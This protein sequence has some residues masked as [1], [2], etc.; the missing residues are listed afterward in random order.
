MD[1]TVLSRMLQVRRAGMGGNQQNHTRL[2]KEQLDAVQCVARAEYVI[3][4][5]DTER[6]ERS[7]VY[8]LEFLVSHCLLLIETSCT[9]KESRHVIDKQVPWFESIVCSCMKPLV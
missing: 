9:A 1:H 6:A 8:I 5:I 3:E 7:I 2:P 4:E